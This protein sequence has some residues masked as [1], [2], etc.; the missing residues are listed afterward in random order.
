[1]VDCQV[2]NYIK[3]YVLWDF[4]QFYLE[5]TCPFE[6]GYKRVALVCNEGANSTTL[7]GW[8]MVTAR[9]CYVSLMVI[10]H[11]VTVQV[12]RDGAYDFPSSSEKTIKFN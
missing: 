12:L 11:I 6:V 7:D 3:A 10:L 5:H 9:V 4:V 8:D 2:L 1:M